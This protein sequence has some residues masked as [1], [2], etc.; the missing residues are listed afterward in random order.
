MHFK[1]EHVLIVLLLLPFGLRGIL[2]IPMVDILMIVGVLAA[3]PILLVYI[4]ERSEPAKIGKLAVDNQMLTKDEVSQ[5]LFCQ[6]HSDEKFGEIAVRR[7]FLKIS[8]MDALL[9]M[10]KI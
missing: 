5:V 9:I 3:L 4:Y 10:Q 1:I 7:N 6:K 2:P 8:D